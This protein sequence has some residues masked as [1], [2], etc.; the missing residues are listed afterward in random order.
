APNQNIPTVM[1][2]AHPSISC[3]DGQGTCRAVC[4]PGEVSIG[5]CDG[6]ACS[7]CGNAHPILITT[8]CLINDMALGNGKSLVV[9]AKCLTY[10]CTNGN[11]IEGNLQNCNIPINPQN[12][13][14]LDGVK[15]F[16]GSSW[17]VGC[18]RHNCGTNGQI[19]ST[20]IPGC[21]EPQ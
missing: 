12:E 7:C 15:Y 16:K 5:K 9:Q 13:C 3:K 2:C 20:L 10:T 17:Q 8:D 21:Q 1:A 4:E 6:L 14:M 18:T 19:T 11:L